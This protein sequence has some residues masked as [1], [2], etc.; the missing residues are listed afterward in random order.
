LLE[1][2]NSGAGTNGDVVFGI[3][4]EIVESWLGYKARTKEKDF[5]AVN[6]EL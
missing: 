4:G 3:T 5:S 2:R 1:I 6:N